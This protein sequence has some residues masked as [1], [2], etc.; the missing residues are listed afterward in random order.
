MKLVD[1]SCISVRSWNGQIVIYD[2]RSGETH[3]L[4][5]SAAWVFARIREA[6]MAQATLLERM[7]VSVESPIEEPAQL[8]RQLLHELNR[9]QLLECDAINGD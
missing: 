8:L 5:G 2:I 1:A 9:H 3:L 6:P 4:E 7:T